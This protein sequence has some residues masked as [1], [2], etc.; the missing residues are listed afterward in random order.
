LQAENGNLIMVY[1]VIGVMSGSSLDGLDI[2]YV[3][4]YETGGKWSYEIIAAKCYPYSGE[5]KDELSKSMHLSAL[6]YQLL[7]SRYGKYIGQQ[8]NRFINVYNLQHKVDLVASHGHTVFHLP[9]FNMTAQ[10]GDGSAIASQIHLPV[11]S[12]L[13]SLDIAFGGQGAPIVP[14]G[15]KLLFKEY[16]CF[17]NIGG[18]A[19]ISF[20]KDG[21]FVAFDV[22]PANR[23][24][25]MLAN[26]K[27]VE[28]DDRGKI[29][30]S[31]K[32]DQQLLQELNNLEY[33][34]K[35]YPKSLDNS[36]GTDI[37]YP[38]IKKSAISVEDALHTYIEYICIQV[39][40]ALNRKHAKLLITGGGAFNDFLIQQLRTSLDNTGI[41]IKVPDEKL[42]QYK[43]ALI[44]ALIGTLRWREEYN[45]LASVTGASQ[46][47][48]GGALW[49]GTE[50]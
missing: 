39:R 31:G 25:N 28:F 15:E 14:I 50:G 21:A 8:V 24:L 35:P 1:K 40:N 13:R 11:V 20:N 48:I 18:I 26:E 6:Q 4:F 22:C 17:L 27:N 10:I 38:L 16:D 41:E 9:E 36:F 7:N 19:N 44:M 43:E 32:T 33:N 34:G 42:V 46:N 45:V 47:S 12:D 29:A 3:H 23:V 5:L 2:A 30:A 37:I 49:L